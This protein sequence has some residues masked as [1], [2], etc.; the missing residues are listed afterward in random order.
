MGN[1]KAQRLYHPR[2]L[3]LK[4]IRHRLKGI[5]GKQPALI[6]EGLHLGIAFL[7]VLRCNVIAA[8]VFLIHCGNYFFL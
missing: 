7:Y 3:L 2:C 4:L 5:L 1:V 6:L 8:A